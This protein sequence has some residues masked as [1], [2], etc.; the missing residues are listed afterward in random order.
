MP[1][2]SN[3]EALNQAFEALKTYKRGVEPEVLKPIEIAVQA[4]YN[5]PAAR[6]ALEKRLAAFLGAP[7]TPATKDFVCRELAL[8]GSPESVPALAALLPDESLSHMARYALDR[9]PGPEADQA[10]RDVL[11][12]TQGKTRIGVINS[13]GVRRDARSVAALA[14]LLNDSPQT[15]GAAAHAL[16]EIGTPE[17]AKALEAF[18][19]NAPEPLRIEAADASLTCAARLIR[20]GHRD[21]GVAILKELNSGKEAPQVLLAASRALSAATRP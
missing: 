2:G 13:V 15:A 10:M 18:R 3:S 7:F 9:I 4:V 5:D 8:I 11:R 14:A 6:R 21:Q 12:T 17:A 20:D 1:Q 19:K 16:G